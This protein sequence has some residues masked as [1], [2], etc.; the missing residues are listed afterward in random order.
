M[1]ATGDWVTPFVYDGATAGPVGEIYTVS[2]GATASALGIW[3]NTGQ[4]IFER[5]KWMTRATDVIEVKLNRDM[6]H[7]YSSFYNLRIADG[8]IEQQTLKG[9]ITVLDD[10]GGGGV[11]VCVCVCACTHGRGCVCVC[12]CVCVCQDRFQEAPRR[13]LQ[14]RSSKIERSSNPNPD[15]EP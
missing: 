14:Y 7:R 1:T 6:I 12:V 11:C 5:D 4:L 15:P 3:D 8:D 2:G 9:L 10:T 13:R